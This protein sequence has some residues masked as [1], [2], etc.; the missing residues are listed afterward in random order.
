MFGDLTQSISM[1]YDVDNMSR[2]RNV[3]VS[4]TSY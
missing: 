4:M 3:F 1:T 2:D